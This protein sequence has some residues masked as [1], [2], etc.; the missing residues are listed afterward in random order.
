M[1]GG[2]RGECVALLAAHPVQASVQVDHGVRAGGGMQAVH[3]LGDHGGDGEGGGGQHREQSVGTAGPGAAELL[4]ADGGA[5]P[6]AAPC[7]VVPHELLVGHGGAGHRIAAPVVRQT[8]ARGHPR[9]AQHRD[10]PVPQQRERLVDLVVVAAQAVARPLHRPPGG[11]TRPAAGRTRA[12]QRA[13]GRG[14]EPA[15]D[16]RRGTGE[17]GAGRGVLGATHSSSVERESV[18]VAPSA[19]EVTPSSPSARSRRERIRWVA[20]PTRARIPIPATIEE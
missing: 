5:R 3:V 17:A 4:P 19:P 14:R 2:A 8:R 7:E 11:Q 6:V 9:P 10:R 12:V 15:A 20:S 1:Q 18:A 16:V 13:G